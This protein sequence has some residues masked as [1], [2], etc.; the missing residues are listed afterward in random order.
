MEAI[1]R[2]QQEDNADLQGRKAALKKQIETIRTQLNQ[3]KEKR[4]ALSMS[5]ADSAKSDIMRAPGR[6]KGKLVVGPEFFDALT[7]E[8]IRELTGE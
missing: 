2:S 7:N 4:V 8:D 6:F 3:L 5:D 1:K